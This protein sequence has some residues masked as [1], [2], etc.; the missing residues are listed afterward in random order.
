MWSKVGSASVA[1]RIMTSRVSSTVPA[2]WIWCAACPMARAIALS[3]TWP[4]Y[5]LLGEGGRTEKRSL[6]ETL[7]L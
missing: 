7:K 5:A 2:V 3:M 1:L 6:H 4:L